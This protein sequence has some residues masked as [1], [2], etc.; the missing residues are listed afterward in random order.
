MA[1][2]DISPHFMGTAPLETAG[3]PDSR[4]VGQQHTKT[5][6]T[7]TQQFNA[8]HFLTQNS[9]CTSFTPHFKSHMVR[10]HL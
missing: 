2:E 1:L 9:I 6:S 5:E 8:R 3:Q 10:S 7:T 4:T